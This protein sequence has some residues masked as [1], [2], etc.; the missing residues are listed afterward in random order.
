MPTFIWGTPLSFVLADVIVRFKALTGHEVFF[1][2]GTDEHGIK[3]LRK[4]EE[5]NTDTQLYVDQYALR[6]P[7]FT[8]ALGMSEHNFIRT[9]DPH[10]KKAAQAFC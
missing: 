10:H 8:R 9:T 4:A 2:T 3:I 5:E 7:D 1:N 6:F